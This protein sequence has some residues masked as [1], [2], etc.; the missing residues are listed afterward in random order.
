[1]QY[2]LNEQGEP[3]RCDDLLTW[4][5]WFQDANRQIVR[6]EI[7]DVTVSTVFLGLDHGFVPDDPPVLFETMVFGGI[8]DQYQE[9][10]QTRDEAIAGHERIVEMVKEPTPCR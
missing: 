1:M 6:S 10:Y 9:R 2:I 4:G 8:A 7:G 5:K 3:E